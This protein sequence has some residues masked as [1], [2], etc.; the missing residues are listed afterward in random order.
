MG[1]SAAN[2]ET[3]N[4]S[5]DDILEVVHSSDD[6]SFNILRESFRQRLTYN[7]I[8][9]QRKKK[10]KSQWFFGKQFFKLNIL[11]RLIQNKKFCKKYI[12]KIYKYLIKTTFFK[13][14]K[15]VNIYLNQQFLKLKK[16]KFFFIK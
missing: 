9:N 11:L 3:S 2:A 4:I 14:N 13:R 1:E 5:Y 16:K 15:I 10:M 8:V 6:P 12:S 7:E